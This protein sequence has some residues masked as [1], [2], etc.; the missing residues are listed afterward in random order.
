MAI[1]NRNTAKSRLGRFSTKSTILN[2]NNLLLAKI[3]IY[4]QY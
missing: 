2:L 3:T 1:A 4:T